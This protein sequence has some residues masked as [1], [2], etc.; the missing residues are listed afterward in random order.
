[1]DL[2]KIDQIINDSLLEIYN[3]EYGMVYSNSFVDENGIKLNYY[4]GD[5]VGKIM[6]D[7]GLV[8]KKGQFYELKSKGIEIIE[9]G[10]YLKHRHKEKG[11]INNQHVTKTLNFNG[12]NYGNVGQNSIF[13]NNPNSNHINSIPTTNETKSMWQKIWK[14][15]DH[16]VISQI[17]IFII[18]IILTYFGFKFLK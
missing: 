1:M 2:N 7:R 10:G 15:T 8:R 4:D 3:S 5:A 12:N 9:S 16:N 14:F 11:N 17:I 6:E 18:T 13:E